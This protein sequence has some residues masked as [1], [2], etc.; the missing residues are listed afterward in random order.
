MD[1]LK[2]C[3]PLLPKHL[4]QLYLRADSGFFFFEFLRFL[5]RRQIKYA[6][7]AKLYNTIQMQLGGLVYR[8]I[9]GVAVSEFE[10]CLTR[11]KQKLPLRMIVIREEIKEDGKG[12]KK[13]PRLLALKG[14]SYQVIVTNIR[15]GAPEEIW[16]FYNV[17]ANV[18]NMIKE[19][20]MGFGADEKSVSLV[21]R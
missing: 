21:C 4:T 6:V 11:G 15:E 18:E 7:V 13:Q 8:D 1:L 17:R 20:A 3:L 16:R 9:G 10:Y 5:E 19:A 14:Y 2:K 12:I